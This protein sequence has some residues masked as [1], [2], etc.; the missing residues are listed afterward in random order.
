[1]NGLFCTFGFCMELA[2]TL[3]ADVSAECFL[4]DGVCKVL[5]K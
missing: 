2:S 1:V 5:L 4:D 3:V